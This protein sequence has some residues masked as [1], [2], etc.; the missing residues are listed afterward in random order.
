MCSK[1]LRIKEGVDA[2]RSSLETGHSLV[3]VLELVLEVGNF[4][5]YGSYN[6]GAYGFRVDSLLL[7]GDYRVEKIN[8]LNILASWTW[9]TY[10]KDPQ[11]RFFSELKRLT[12]ALKMISTLDLDN[13]S[14]EI[15]DL[16][17]SV[18]NSHR[19]IMLL[20]EAAIEMVE[21][22]ETGISANEIVSLM[23]AFIPVRRISRC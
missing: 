11:S 18:A 19:A 21:E 17:A 6:G 20:N 23:Q 9:Q 1:L 16:A 15:S 7:L 8:L 3:R 12:S 22:A 4:L 14:N 13:F 2:L 10:G 5:N